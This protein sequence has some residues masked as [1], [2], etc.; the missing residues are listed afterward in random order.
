MNDT[1]VV[2]KRIPEL[3]EFLEANLPQYYSRNDVLIS[4]ILFRYINN[5]DIYEN[6]LVWIKN[7]YDNDKEAIKKEL[8]RLESTFATEAIESF[9]NNF[10]C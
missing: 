5:E 4:D 7:E 1:E 3:W 8:I 6:E 9:Y 10:K 2:N